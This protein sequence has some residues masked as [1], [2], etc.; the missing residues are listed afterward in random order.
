LHGQSEAVI[1]VVSLCLVE[2][3][4]H[5]YVMSKCPGGGHW[6]TQ[7]SDYLRVFQNFFL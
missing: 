4:P 3:V 6:K 5:Y 1:S 7:S 2:I